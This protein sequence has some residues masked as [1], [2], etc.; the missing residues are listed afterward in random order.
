MSSD[1]PTTSD[2]VTRL[3]GGRTDGTTPRHLTQAE[4]RTLDRALRRS[5]QISEPTKVPA[6][7]DMPDP[8]LPGGC[9]SLMHG[10][11]SDE[12]DCGRCWC[13]RKEDANG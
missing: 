3:R 13:K 9:W 2:I 4:Q 12:A 10:K 11:I 7:C 8:D 6:W 1:R 5:M